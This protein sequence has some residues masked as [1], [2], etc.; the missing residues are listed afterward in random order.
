MA[1]SFRCWLDGARR[2][3]G[4]PGIVFAVWALSLALALPLGV[5]LRGLLRAH[6]G[7]S[8][9]AGQAA[10]GV[11]YDWW[12]EFLYQTGGI[13]STFVPSIIGFAAPLKNI[14]DLLDN[15]SLAATLGSIVTVWLVLWAFMAGGIFDRYARGRTTH[16]AGFFAACGVFF[17][18]F[19]RLGAMAAIAY[20]LLFAYVHGWLF[21]GL[22]GRWTRDMTV[23]RNAFFAR[24]SLYVLFA[25]LLALVNIVV[26]YA[27]VRA[28]VE[29]R[30]SMIGALVGGARFV[31]RHPAATATLYLLNT[32]LFLVLLLIYRAVA[33]GA[34]WSGAG[35]WV[36]FAISQAYIAAR[37]WLKLVFAASQ[38]SLF[39]SR[40]AHAGYA[41]FAGAPTLEPPVVEALG[42]P[43]VSAPPRP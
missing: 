27:K 38:I 22:L 29:D 11:N 40:L 16:T 23:E 36:A 28:V 33:P 41:A 34:S 4:A 39:Q 9:A 20:W 18:R 17:V 1:S 31:F 42:P 26:D 37:V 43:P 6:L 32:V 8:L 19:L 7:D 13:G 10:E 2:V 24:V 5:V 12:N 21:E 14:S 35:I 3:N 30:R 25:A 15:E